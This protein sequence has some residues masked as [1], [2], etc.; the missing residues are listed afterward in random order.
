MPTLLYDV[1]G[2]L[3]LNI[4]R[5]LALG[6]AAVLLAIA[7]F[8]LHLPMFPHSSANTS[9]VRHSL[10]QRSGAVVSVLGS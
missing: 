3:V 8:L 9:L 10:Q 6:V 1:R 2:A 4:F 7:A 5:E